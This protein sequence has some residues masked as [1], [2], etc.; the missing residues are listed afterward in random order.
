MISIAGL[1]LAWLVYDAAVQT[2]A[3][4]ER[5]LAALVFAFICVSAWGACELFSARAAYIQVGAMIGTMM[6]GNVFFVIIPAQRELVRAKKEGREPDPSL[7]KR[8]KTRSVHN[9]YLTLPVV[10]AMLVGP[11]SVHVRRT[12]TPGSCCVALM[13]IGALI[14]A[15]LQPAPQGRGTSGGSSSPRRAGL[16]ALALADRAEDASPRP[17]ADQPPCLRTVQAIVAAALR[18]VPLHASR[19]RSARHRWG[20]ARHAAGDRVEGGADRSIRGRRRTR[21]RSATRPG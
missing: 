4:D 2:F 9:N 10:F 11:L 12:G 8:G 14:A 21:C 7:G 18:S 6:V 20:S 15:L 13:A 5:I 1:A 3:N 17:P 19:R 16:V